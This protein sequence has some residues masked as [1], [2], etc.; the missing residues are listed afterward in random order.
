M[1]WW[2]PRNTLKHDVNTY[3]LITNHAWICHRVWANFIRGNVDTIMQLWMAWVSFS[4]DEH[5]VLGPFH[6]H[7]T[8]S[9]RILCFHSG[10]QW[11]AI[12]ITDQYIQK[13]SVNILNLSNLAKRHQDSALNVWKSGHDLLRLPRYSGKRNTSRKRSMI[14]LSVSQFERCAIFG[15]L[16]TLVISVHGNSSVDPFQL[17]KILPTYFCS[18][19][20]V[21]IS[22]YFGPLRKSSFLASTSTNH[23]YFQILQ[24]YF[25]FVGDKI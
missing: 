23:F 1:H 9:Y 16:E 24:K 11:P 14:R 10:M 2:I 18:S 19:S 20:F 3:S 25:S 12:R 6:T 22:S 4:R 17:P 8:D 7:I 13:H 5:M 21:F 15:L